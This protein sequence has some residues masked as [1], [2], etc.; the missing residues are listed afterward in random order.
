MKYGTLRS[1]Y[2][3]AVSP[4]MRR[5]WIEI[6]SQL[7]TPGKS[8]TSPSMR[9]EWIEI[10]QDT[11]HDAHDNKSPSMRREWIEMTL[12]RQLDLTKSVSLHAEGVD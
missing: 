10:Q 4:S 6:S 8:Q 9:R 2:K 12:W 1:A 5:E 7:G 3:V 11:E